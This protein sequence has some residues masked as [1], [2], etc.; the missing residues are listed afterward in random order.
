VLGD[1]YMRGNWNVGGFES[2]EAVSGVDIFSGKDSLAFGFADMADSST[3]TEGS[4]PLVYDAVNSHARPDLK[5]SVQ[6]HRPEHLV[7]FLS[8]ISMTQREIFRWSRDVMLYDVSHLRQ[9]F[10]KLTSYID[11]TPY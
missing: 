6:G 8:H 10:R 3:M 1:G 7:F 4:R 9:A 5:Q 2:F 11:H